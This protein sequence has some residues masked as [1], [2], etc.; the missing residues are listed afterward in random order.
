MNKRSKLFDFP[1]GAFYFKYEGSDLIVLRLYKV[2]TKNRFILRDKDNHKVSLTKDQLEEF[3]MLEPDGLI[4]HVIVSDPIQGTDTVCLL[5][6]MNELNNGNNEPY[7]VCRQNIIDPFEIL[8]NNDSNKTIVGVSIS[9]DTA[10]EGFDFKTTYIATGIKYQQ[11]NFVYKD[12]SFEDIMSFVNKKIFDGT[13]EIVSDIL[14]DDDENSK[15]KF[16]GYNSTY[17]DLL[18][19]NDFMYDFRRAFGIVRI[20]IAIDKSIDRWSD[21][22]IYKISKQEIEDIESITKHLVIAPVLIKYDKT[23]DLTEIKRSYIIFEDSNKE[24][25]VIS[26]DKG[27]YINREY[28]ALSDKR[29][30]ELL[31]N[32][33]AK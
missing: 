6:R 15:L 21:D 32:K 5:Y 3:T 26:Y 9:R 1:V 2:K 25:Y 29:D 10:P 28:D 18:I 4:V 31:Q 27:N 8:L 20:N 30:R 22:G 23:V 16:I 17:K 13:L 33:I 11:V 19:Q 14:D 7:A 24:I 12:D